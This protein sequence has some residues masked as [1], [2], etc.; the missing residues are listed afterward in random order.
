MFELVPSD[1][2]SPINALWYA[3]SLKWLKKFSME[4]AYKLV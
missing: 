3:L 1:C 4:I 2:M